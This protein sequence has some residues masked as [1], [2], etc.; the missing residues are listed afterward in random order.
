MT[1]A[2]SFPRKSELAVYTIRFLSYIY[3]FSPFL[4][5]LQD[6]CPESYASSTS[7]SDSTTHSPPHPFMQQGGGPQQAPPPLAS[8]GSRPPPLTR[9]SSEASASIHTRMAEASISSGQVS[10][11]MALPPPPPSTFQRQVSITSPL[12][13]HAVHHNSTQNLLHSSLEHHSPPPVWQRP[14]PI[15]TGFALYGQ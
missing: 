4:C 8:L 9:V 3:K 10:P 13:M 6:G 15:P 5:S 2:I 7:E 12:A 14:S 1:N 11:I